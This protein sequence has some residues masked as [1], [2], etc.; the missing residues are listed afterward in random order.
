[1]RSAFLFSSK[2]FMPI[3]EIERVFFRFLYS[4]RHNKADTRAIAGL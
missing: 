3:K 2:A 4:R 1:M